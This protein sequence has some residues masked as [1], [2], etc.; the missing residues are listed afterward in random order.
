AGGPARAF[1]FDV[2]DS[3][4]SRVQAQVRRLL[5]T[6]TARPRR[7]VGDIVPVGRLLDDFGDALE[8][9]QKERARYVLYQDLLKQGRLSGPNRLFLQARFLAAFEEWDSFDRL[10]D[11]EDLLRLR[12]PALVSDA[13]ARLA[14]HHLEAADDPGVE[15]FTH[16]VAARF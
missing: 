12:R 15:A 1:R 5:N 11:L 10:P 7:A 9:G 8:Q 6:W 13:L 3:E 2:V 16:T 14:L 4:R